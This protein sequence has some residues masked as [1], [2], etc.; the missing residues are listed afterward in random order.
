MV[1]ALVTRATSALTYMAAGA[2]LG[3]VI[4]PVMYLGIGFAAGWAAHKHFKGDLGALRD[5]GARAAQGA[6]RLLSDAIDAARAPEK[7]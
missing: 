4:R 3:A 2:A 5:E 7:K 1:A 6:V